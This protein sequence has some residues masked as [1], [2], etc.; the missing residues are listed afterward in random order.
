[1]RRSGLIAVL[2]AGFCS[3][4]GSGSANA[5]ATTDASIIF[6]IDNVDCSAPE[7]CIAQLDPSRPRLDAVAVATSGMDVTVTDSIDFSLHLSNPT[8]ATTDEQVNLRIDYIIP[9]ISVTDG[10][11]DSGEYDYQLTAPF[12]DYLECSY[13]GSTG[14]GPTGPPRAGPG[15]YCGVLD[16]NERSFIV[17]PGMGQTFELTATLDA[18]ADSVPEPSSVVILAAALLILQ[19]LRTTASRRRTGIPHPAATRQ[20]LGPPGLAIGAGVALPDPAI[21]RKISST[22][23]G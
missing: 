7:G 13:P 20:W 2:V 8:D 1:M 17:A 6:G 22:F 14:P 11:T 23:V 5:T 9:G 18:R 16:F 3:I 15:T 19:G 10:L 4:L 21:Y 12:G